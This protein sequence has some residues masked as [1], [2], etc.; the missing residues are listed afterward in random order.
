MPAY[1]LLELGCEALDP[2][3]SALAPDRCWVLRAGAGCR[4]R[5]GHEGENGDGASEMDQPPAISRDML[6]A[7]RAGPQKG[8][9]LIIATAEPPG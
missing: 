3:L 7:T 5:R 2:D 9:Q 6:S 4:L 8:P 1:S